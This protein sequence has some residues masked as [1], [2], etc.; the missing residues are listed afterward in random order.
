M[1]EKREIKGFT[2][3]ELLIVVAIVSVLVAIGIP[4]FTG[5][6]EKS[7]EATDIANIRAQYAEVIAEAILTGEDV[8]INGERI[9][10]IVL[11]QKQ[12]DWNTSTIKESI[13][14]IANVEGNP[15]MPQAGGSA[16]VEYKDGKVTIHYSLGKNSNA[17]TAFTSI[18]KIPNKALRDVFSSGTIVG[19]VYLQND[20]NL[21]NYLQEKGITDFTKMAMSSRGVGKNASEPQDEYASVYSELG[22][23]YNSSDRLISVSQTDSPPVSKETATFTQLLYTW[24]AKN[25]TYTLRA[26][27]EVTG[28]IVGL[29]AG[30]NVFTIQKIDKIS[31]STEW[32]LNK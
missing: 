20:S 12:D 6:L 13:D 22:I 21:T 25:K 30:N 24:D 5:Q 27:R 8:N 17:V 18:S 14:S 23:S 26:T 11:K 28:V 3:A 9:G 1:S 32:I 7:R 2:L 15:N 10:K 31:N 16:W 4:I 19:G 29:N